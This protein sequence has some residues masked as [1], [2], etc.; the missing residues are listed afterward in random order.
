MGGTAQLRTPHMTKMRICSK[1]RI[2]LFC[3][4]LWICLM[5]GHP[6]FGAGVSED[7]RV[8]SMNASQVI[9]ELTL[10]EFNIE[11]VLGPD[12]STFAQIRMPGWARTA[13]P[14]Y[15]E[16][17]MKRVLLQIPNQGVM[18]MKILEDV[19]DPMSVPPIY[20]VPRQSLSDQGEPITTF[21]KDNAAYSSERLYPEAVAALGPPS[22]LRGT[23]AVPLDIRP[24]QWDPVA[25][26]LKCHHR[27]RV[28]IRMGETGAVSDAPAI[29]ST[30]PGGTFES[31]KRQTLI[32]YAPITTVDQRTKPLT[33]SGQAILSQAV[34]MEVVQDGIYALT[35]D[36]MR[37]IGIPSGIDPRSFQLFNRGNE[38]AIYVASEGDVFTEGDR[39]FFYGQGI[40]TPYSETNVYFLH[41]GQETGRRMGEIDGTVTGGGT[42][43]TTFNEILHVEENHTLWESMPGAPEMDFWFWERLTAPKAVDYAVQILSPDPEGPDATFRVA[44][45]GRSTASPHPNHHTVIYLNGTEVSNAWWD[46]EIPYVQEMT[47]PQDLLIDGPNTLTVDVPGD[48]GATADVVYFNRVEIS[49]TRMLKAVDDLLRFTVRGDGRFKMNISNLS[50]PDIQILDITDPA[51]PK[52][53]N[54]KT[55]EPEG[56][57]YQA[58]FEDDI[59]GGKSYWVTASDL[60]GSPA[61]MSLWHSTGLERPENGA[62]WILVTGEDMVASALPLAQFRASQGLRV[63]VVGMADVY[64]EFNFGLTDPAA[65]KTFLQYAYENWTPPA[66]TYVFFMGDA[67]TDYR[68]YL[69]S[70]KQNIVPP[71]L[72]RTS[73]GVTPEDNWYVCM[74]GPDDVLPD[75]FVGRMPADGPAMAETLINKIVGFENSLWPA[76]EKALFVADN[77]DSS[78]E[79]LNEALIP[80]LPSGFGVDRVYLGD[81]SNVSQATEDIISHMDAGEI[82]TNYVGHGSVTNWAGEYL[83]DSGDVP[84]LANPDR[85]TFVIAMTC[86]NGY[87]SQPFHYCLT[88]EIVGASQK[89]AIAGFAPSGLGYVWEHGLLDTALFG[90][91]FED[92]ESVVGP[93]TIGAKIA[94]YG[95]GVTPDV[96]RTF[97]LFGDPA[98]RLKIAQND[99]AVPEIRADGFDGPVAVLPNEPVDI[100]VSLFPGNHVGRTCDWWLGAGTPMGTY[101]C[102]PYPAWTRSPRPVSTGAFGLFDLSATTVLDMALPVGIYTFTFGLDVDANGALDALDGYDYV[103]VISADEPSSIQDVLPDVKANGQDIE[104]AATPDDSVNITLALDPGSQS[105]VAC[106]WWIGASTPYG[107]FWYDVASGWQESSVP[108]PTVTAG[109][110][111]VDSAGLL[112]TPLPVGVYTFFFMLDQNPNGI[113]DDISWYDLVNVVCR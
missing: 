19:C 52:L 6:A 30:S 40:D 59:V 77:N 49:Y 73:L 112:D 37:A 101:W 106:D 42:S 68:D 92:K 76:A 9:L 96:M 18:D 54:P 31:L 38:V 45:Q 97:T 109:L 93:A 27:I 85:L 22:A 60:I 34:R 86:L 71:Q 4:G 14:G 35:Y 28:A 64:N 94:A 88:E 5:A 57:V 1:T 46:G 63:Q 48:T 51:N 82:L 32:N 58:V 79:E 43:V 110:F 47:A 80:Y 23:S 8:I 16:L 15:P 105:G 21:Y 91:L 100:T 26:M 104:C 41:W 95:E 90:K 7:V 17:P 11:T 113:L 56:D 29:G 10:P 62:D 24:F 99:R 69:G 108:L 12:G 98:T 39:I 102:S 2:I 33:D 44:F 83:F 72:S 55:V 65:L 84:L 67:N 74:D 3:F 53:V 66:P 87:F 50:G 70:G 36:E 103:N 81:Y 61:Q 107:T 111:P 25:N 75:M 78:F 13:R 89:G 20:P